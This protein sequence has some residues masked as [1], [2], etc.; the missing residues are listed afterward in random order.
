MTV[1]IWDNRDKSYSPIETLKLFKDSV[2]QVQAN[3]YEIIC[4]SMDG[5]VTFFDIRKGEMTSDK[6]S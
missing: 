6:L 2:T 1:K 5:S 3:D 4:G